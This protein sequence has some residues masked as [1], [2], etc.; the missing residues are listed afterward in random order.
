MRSFASLTLLA[1]SV[2]FGAVQASPAPAETSS[3]SC[4]AQNI[5]DACLSSTQPQLQACAQNDWKCLCEQSTNV[6]TCYN[7]CPGDSG[8]FGAQQTKESYCNAANAY[9]PSSS[10]TSTAATSTG[11]ETSIAVASTASGSNAVAT[12]GSGASVT[13]GGSSA[14]GTASGS[15]ATETAKSA[16]SAFA[17]NSGSLSAALLLAMGFAL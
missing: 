6:L 8:Q 3:S 1:L 16:G 5:L 7:N 4:A 2:S 13:S 15:S 9:A 14:T 11:I 17:I 12:G 10:T